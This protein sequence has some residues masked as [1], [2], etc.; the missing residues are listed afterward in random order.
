MV[1]EP[2]NGNPQKWPHFISA[3][4]DMVRADSLSTGDKMRLF[5][6]C[7]AERIQDGLGL[8][9]EDPNLYDDAIEELSS[10]YGNPLLVSR[11]IISKICPAESAQRVGFLNLTSLFYYSPRRGRHAAIW[12][13]RV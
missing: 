6:S 1:I 13:F 7:L 3:F 8:L 9:L 4:N 10:T 11:V 12:R 5:K 2:F